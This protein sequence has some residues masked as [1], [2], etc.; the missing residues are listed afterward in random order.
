M[1]PVVVVALLCLLEACGGGPA[2]EADAGVAREPVDSGAEP[3][4]ASAADAGVNDAG[5]GLDAGEPDA[6]L[7]DAGAAVDAGVND[8]GVVVD[9]GASVDAGAPDAGVAAHV[10]WA[11]AVIPT[12]SHPAVVTRNGDNFQQQAFDDVV[13]VPLKSG[14]E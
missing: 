13:F 8:T 9:A 5:A 12:G 3:V 6:G 2:P 14:Q 1:K 7:V 10:G 4:D 11:S